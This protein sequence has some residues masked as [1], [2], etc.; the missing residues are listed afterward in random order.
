MKNI[1]LPPSAPLV[2]ID[3]ESSFL[4]GFEYI[5]KKEGFTQVRTFD[6]AVDALSFITD[7]SICGIFLD[8]VMPGMQG[9]EL[10][11]KLSEIRPEIPVVMLTALPEPSLIVDCIK[12]GAYDYLVKPVERIDLINTAKRISELHRLQLENTYLRKSLDSNLKTTPEVFQHILTQ[13]S[14]MF[15][16]FEYTENI[17]FSHFPVLVRGETGTGKELFAQAIHNLSRPNKPFISENIASLDST[18]LNSTLF[19]HTQGAFTGATTKKIGLIE[20]A[21]DGVLFLDEIGDLTLESQTKLLRVLQEEEYSPIGSSTKQKLKCRFIFATHQ[22]LEKKIKEGSFRQD[23]FYRIQAHQISIPPLRD[24]VKDISLIANHYIEKFKHELGI[25]KLQI[26][27]SLT[28]L[29]ESYSW[30]GNIR[31]LQTAIL[32][33]VSQ[34]RNGHLLFEPFYR[35][36]KQPN[37]SDSSISQQSSIGQIESLDLKQMELTLIK[38]ALEQTNNNQTQAAALL[39]IKRDTLNKKIKRL[40]L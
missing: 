8:I 7:N 28:N 26:P 32:D 11:E 40:E 31:Q 25:N 29:L 34:S 18:L 23:L 36:I 16:L 12:K 35:F 4:K 21:A 27:N 38:A 39:G 17:S 22:N 5:L 24:R 10:L 15:Q 30:P 1:T 2:L 3:D 19:G 13:D 33:A 9:T 14:T 20:L 37:H 6:N